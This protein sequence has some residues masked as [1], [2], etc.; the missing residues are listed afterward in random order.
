MQNNDILLNI[1]PEYPKAN[2]AVKASLSTF[3]T[4][5]D[6]A[7]IS[8]ILNGTLALEG[9]GKK[10]FSFSIGN[11]ALQTNLEAKVETVNGLIINKK[12]TIS[13]SN[14]DLIWEAIDTYVPPFYK[15]KALSPIGGSIKIV[16]M[17]GTKNVSGFKYSWKKDNKNNSDSSGYE[18][19]YFLYKNNFLEKGNIIEVAVSDLMGNKIGSNE[20]SMTPINPKIVFYEKDFLLGTKWEKATKDGFTINK[21]GTT[22][23]AEPYF[24]SQKDTSSPDLTFKWSINNQE[25]LMSDQK[26]LL[27][28]KPESGK[29]GN[30]NIKVTIKNNKTLFQETIKK[31]NVNF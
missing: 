5:L 10:D 25:P 13:T 2:E 6:T 4:D 20:I 26:N 9:I 11:N 31:I 18:K 12:T 1:N 28:I 24:F 3:T 22:L 7:K 21:D 17:P 16:A 15:G 19:N 30:S 27:S 14:I 8:W 23:M 29:S